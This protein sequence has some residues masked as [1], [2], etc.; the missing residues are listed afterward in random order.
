MGELKPKIAA[1][2]TN[3]FCEQLGIADWEVILSVQDDPPGWCCEGSDDTIG[4]STCATPYKRAKIWVSPGRCKAA[5]D[6]ELSTLFH[7]L[8]HV[9]AIDSGMVG[10]E[11]DTP[12]PLEYVFNRLS[13][14]MEKAV[15]GK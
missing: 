12:E 11:D 10:P 8:M 9:V 3:W 4:R 1:K 7:E 6:T 15:K 2:A 5:N 13:Y 14:L